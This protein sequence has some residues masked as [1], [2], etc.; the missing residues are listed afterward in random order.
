MQT[1]TA[2]RHPNS[3]Y[4]LGPMAPE[5]VLS[6]AASLA[7]A[8]RFTDATDLVR[9]LAQANL[10][11]WPYASA[12][13]DLLEASNMQG[14]AIASLQDF[15]A[16]SSHTIEAWSRLAGML[17]RAGQFQ[18]AVDAARQVTLQRPDW[19]QAHNRLGCLLEPEEPELALAAFS[20]ASSLAEEWITPR[21]NQARLLREQASHL[22]TISLLRNML[23]RGHDHHQVHVAL[24]EALLE[25]GQYDEGWQ[26]YE[27]RFDAGGQT[28]PFPGTHAPV[29]DGS[30]LHRRIL[31][32][33]LEQGLGDQLQFCRYLPYIAAL[34]GRIWL[35]TPRVLQPLLQSLG[36]VERF[37]NEGDTAKGFDLQ[38]PLLSLPRVLAKVLPA[39]PRDIYLSANEVLP[40]ATAAL[41]STPAATL[42]VGL[43]HAS[44]ADHPSAARR[45]CPLQLLSKLAEIPNVRLYDMQYDPGAPQPLSDGSLVNLRSVLGNFAQT[46]AI[47]RELDLVITVD[48]AMAH[49]C[50]AIG[51]PVWTLLSRPCDWRWQGHHRESVWYP[52]MRLYR[53][54]R[55]GDWSSPLNEVVRDLAALAQQKA[56]C[57]GL[58]Q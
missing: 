46:A 9:P 42:R 37:V 27:W 58:P 28:P 48:T 50:G 2:D 19:P 44:R 47:V 43:V 26:A 16:R 33:W 35:Q 14:Q 23:A 57:L 22:E 25:D 6:I 5:A 17:N 18:A 20:R 52:S 8:G 11:H 41:I 39:I 3:L 51:H 56:D 31:M 45:D 7:N 40:A 24:A 10:D 34:G 13:A 36:V 53:Q 32:V 4:G 38:I 55:R 21:L 15:V 30:P 12:L 29:W 49:L 1:H 54:A